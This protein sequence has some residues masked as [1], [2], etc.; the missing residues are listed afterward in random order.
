M[1]DHGLRVGLLE[2]RFELRTSRF[3]LEARK[4]RWWPPNEIY[5]E[6]FPG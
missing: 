1:K 5:G 4:R 6:G 2:E 3:R